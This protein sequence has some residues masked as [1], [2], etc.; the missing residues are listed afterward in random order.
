MVLYLYLNMGTNS[1][2]QWVFVFGKLREILGTKHKNMRFAQL[3]ISVLQENA[4]IDFSI[5]LLNLKSCPTFYFSVKM[6]I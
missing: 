1:S 6:S 2:Y 4:T 3:N 5:V